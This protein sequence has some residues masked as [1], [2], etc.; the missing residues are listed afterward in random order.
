MKFAKTSL[1]AA[2]AAM[3]MVAAS[4]AFAGGYSIAGGGTTATFSGPTY[5]SYL[6]VSLPCIATFYLTLNPGGATAKVTAAT[7]AD[8]P[9]AT[10]CSK[11]TTNLGSSTWS[12]STPSSGNLTISGISVTIP[13]LGVTC[14]GSVSG[15]LNNSLSSGDFTFSGSLSPGCGVG[16]NPALTSSPKVTWF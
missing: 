8:Y 12:V 11:I 4:S 1:K 3:G 9:P 13:F 2:L 7:F 10:G 14:T 16:S 6:G 5:A 15:T